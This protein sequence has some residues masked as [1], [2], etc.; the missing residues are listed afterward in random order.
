MFCGKRYACM[1]NLKSL[2]KWTQIL[3]NIGNG[4]CYRLKIFYRLTTNIIFSNTFVT[5]TS[6]G[7]RD[8]TFIEKY[9]VTK[10]SEQQFSKCF[11]KYSIACFASR[12][13]RNAF[14]KV[15]GKLWGDR[16]KPY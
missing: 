14:E 7:H 6:Q 9:D 5:E 8:K 2:D 3:R 10:D 15:G 11:C 12:H 1:D 13:I 16:M 4:T